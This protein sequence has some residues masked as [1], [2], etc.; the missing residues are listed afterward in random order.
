M[1]IYGDVLE[2]ILVNFS[3]MNLFLINFFFWCFCLILIFDLLNFYYFC[4]NM[5]ISYE[6]FFFV[7]FMFD[8]RKVDYIMF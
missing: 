5:F 3:S 2:N 4:D 7:C 1:I 8:I 6:D